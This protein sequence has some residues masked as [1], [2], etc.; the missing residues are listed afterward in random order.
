MMVF[1]FVSYL[2]KEVYVV[3]KS[4]IF[5]LAL[6]AV[7]LLSLAPLLYYVNYIPAQASYY[8]M[9]GYRAFQKG[10][11]VQADDYYTKA[12]A[13]NTYGNNEYR[14]RHAEF[15]DTVSER[16]LADENFIRPIILK[17]EQELKKQVEDEPND[18]S[19]YL[20][21]MRHYVYTGRYNPEYYKR[22][23]DLFQ[24]AAPLSPTRQN[25]Y[26]EAGYAQ[27]FLADYYRN[28]GNKDTSDTYFKDA[29]ANFK[30]SIELNP[31]VIE[32][33]INLVSAYL[34]SGELDEAKAYLQY[35]DTNHF[36]YH[37][38]AHLRRLGNTAVENERYEFANIFYKDIINQ[39]YNVLLASGQLNGEIWI[40]DLVNL[41]LSYAYLG[42][43]DKAIET[44]QEVLLVF[45]Q[46]TKNV[47][48]FIANVKSGVFR[49]STKRKL[50]NKNKKNP[51][52]VEGVT[53][54][55]VYN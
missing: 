12:I 32:S 50:F 34:A 51:I 26:D 40:Q 25:L 52:Q 5:L 41:A 28:L 17:V 23:L 27:V 15:I 35:M 10:E 7:Y 37:K 6:I 8:T 46:N 14:L 44:A 11:L 53:I 9:A 31:D 39:G 47:E 20:L 42:Q 49:D 54:E 38:H 30:K 2:D 29:Y 3:P 24:K 18:V 1:G 45:P 16:G 19:N 4:K 13:F 22:V 55:P 43:D 33:H 21:L 36:D 48:E